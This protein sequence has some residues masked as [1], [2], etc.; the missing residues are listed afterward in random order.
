[1]LD[2]G[3]GCQENKTE[4]RVLGQGSSFRQRYEERKEKSRKK[5]RR[6]KHKHTYS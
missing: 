3:K 4:L 5:G 2:P 6:K 1:M